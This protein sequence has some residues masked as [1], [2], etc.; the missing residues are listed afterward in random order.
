M[1]TETSAG[2]AATRPGHGS[3]RARAAQQIELVTTLFRELFQSEQSALEHPR[4]EAQRLGDVPPAAPMYAIAAHAESTLPEIRALAAERELP[5]VEAGRAFGS[6]FSTLRQYAADLLLSH[7]KS[8]RGTILGARH[9]IDLVILL[10][11]VATEAED[12]LLAAWCGGWLEVRR[13]LVERAAGELAWFAENPDLAM[14]P[15]NDSP[16]AHGIQAI[17]RG[18][19]LWV[20]RFSRPRAA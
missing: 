15:V 6:A 17:V 11:D 3:P 20:G 8:Y 2:S 12:P 7:E 9:G 18:V 19:E 14:R 10:E 4:V 13:P 16:L 1:H 5:A